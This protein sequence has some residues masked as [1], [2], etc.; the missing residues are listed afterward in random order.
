MDGDEEWVLKQVIVARFAASNC[1]LPAKIEKANK[2]HERHARL[3]FTGSGQ[4][5]DTQKYKT[6]QDE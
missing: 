4:T 1:Y 3:L 5:F 2:C 6:L